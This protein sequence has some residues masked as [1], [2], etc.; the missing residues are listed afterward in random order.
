M[1][2][3]R[4]TLKFESIRSMAILW[5]I[6]IF[7]IT[8]LLISAYFSYKN[9][10]IAAED[11]LKMQ[12]MGIAVTLQSF[13]QSESL[14]NLQENNRDFLM[15]IILNENWENVA[16]IALY[17]KKGYIVL[18]SNPDLIGKKIE[19]FSPDLNQKYPYFHYLI[20]STFEKVF[21]SDFNFYIDK[22]PYFLRIA[23]HI[24]PAEV[25]LKRTRLYIFLK[26][27]GVIGLVVF[28]ILGTIL[29]KKFEDIQIKIKELKSL[30]LMTKILAHEIR[31]PLSSIKGFSQYLFKKID[32]EKIKKCLQIIYNEALRIER[33]TDELLLYGNPVKLEISKFNFKELIEE[34]ILGFKEKYPEI[35]FQIQILDDLWIQSDKDK[36][37]EIVSNLLQNSVDALMETSKKEKRIV[38][39]VEKA[40]NLIKFGIIDNGAGMDEKTLAKAMEPFFTTKV[41]GSGLG[42]AIVKKLCD[43]LKIK[44]QIKSKKEEGTRV[45]LWIPKSL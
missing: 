35:I 12:A 42:L 39:E 25:I 3:K 41:W 20:L 1:G 5:S 43:V 21:V 17:D 24:Y 30:A 29:L 8:I 32:E 13:F 6:I 18:H 22:K 11:A 14:K 19:N 40:K 45:Y 15:D 37:K 4:L 33:L 2:I 7:S 16:F 31:N 9:S 27:A 44:I 26:I 36:L 34:L 10:K 28:G 23:L 38:L